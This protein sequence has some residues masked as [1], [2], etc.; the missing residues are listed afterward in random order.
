VGLLYGTQWKE[1]PLEVSDE[2]KTME[3]KLGIYYRSIE[4]KKHIP[5]M[6]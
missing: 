3:N 1:L 4:Y 6:Y 5:I 2:E